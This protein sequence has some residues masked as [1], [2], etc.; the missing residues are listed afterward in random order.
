MHTCTPTPT[1]LYTPTL[2]QWQTKITVP[3]SDSQVMVMCWVGS[4]SNTVLDEHLF[5]WRQ[6]ACYISVYIIY[7]EYNKLWRERLAVTLNK[8]A[9][10]LNCICSK[11]HSQNHSLI[12]HISQSQAQQ[13]CWGFHFE[14]MSWFWLSVKILQFRIAY[15]HGITKPDNILS[16]IFCVY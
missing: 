6:H 9:W 5:P 7:A 8:T 11:L 10:C 2:H 16:Y 3:S 14:N 12:K 1:R 4:V 15:W 13:N